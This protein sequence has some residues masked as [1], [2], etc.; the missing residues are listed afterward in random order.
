MGGNL[1]PLTEYSVAVQIKA[2]LVSIDLQQVASPFVHDSRTIISLLDRKL[3]WQKL[4]LA[5]V[6]ELEN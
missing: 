4:P 3:Q 1:G 6:I 2:W 5:A